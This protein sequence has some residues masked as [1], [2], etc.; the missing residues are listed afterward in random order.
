MPLLWSE[1]IPLTSICFSEKSCSFVEFFVFHCGTLPLL[2]FHNIPLR[3]SS[4]WRV[5]FAQYHHRSHLK[6]YD[7]DSTLLWGLHNLLSHTSSLNNYSG[8]GILF[9]TGNA[10]AV[11]VNSWNVFGITNN[12]VQRYVVDY[13]CKQYPPKVFFLIAAFKSANWFLPLSLYFKADM[14]R[15]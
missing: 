14:F 6:G 9:L 10:K 7:G 2:M 3:P 1:G 13:F 15:R 8:L 12:S 11:T 4:S 5:F